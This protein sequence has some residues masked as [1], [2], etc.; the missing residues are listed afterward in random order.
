MPPFLANV[1][2]FRISKGGIMLRER[3]AEALKA[4]M[5]A[6]DQKALSTLRL[7]LAALKDRGI[8]ARSKGNLEGISDDEILG[9]L[10]S[11]IKQRRESIALYEKGGRLELAE[12]EAEEIATIEKFLPEQMG[13][14]EMFDVITSLIVEIEA[15]NLK[16]MGRTMAALK[17]RYAGRMDFAK[18][19]QMVKAQLGN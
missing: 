18:A 17:E 5:K 7:I 4:A 15:Q 9:M 1:F 13:D 6:K 3:L 11:M 2:V 16:D 10:Q 14:E 12:G 19:S 8:A